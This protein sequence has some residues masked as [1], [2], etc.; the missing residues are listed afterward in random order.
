[1][2]LNLQSFDLCDH[3]SMLV[4]VVARVA[5]NTGNYSA[6]SIIA[7]NEEAKESFKH[8]SQMI[9]NLNGKEMNLV[10]FGPLHSGDTYK[11]LVNADLKSD[12]PIWK[13]IA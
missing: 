12:W 1:M 3:I 7:N 11:I 9:K 6:A 4:D 13:K 2:N 10:E 8:L 5:A